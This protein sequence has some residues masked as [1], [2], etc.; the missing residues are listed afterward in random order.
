[1]KSYG[2]RLYPQLLVTL[3]LLNIFDHSQDV[4]LLLRYIF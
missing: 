2:F 4:R 1:M 3:L